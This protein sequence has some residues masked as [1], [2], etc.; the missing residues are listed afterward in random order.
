MRWTTFHEHG[1]GPDGSIYTFLPG[2]EF[3][4]LS[5]TDGS[6]INSAGVLQPIDTNL[7]PLTAVDA[8][9][10]V[11]V[12]NG[13][14]SNPV[15]NGRVWAFSPDLQTLL[16]TLVLNRQNIGGP[17]LAADGT[18]IVADLRGVFAYRE[19]LSPTPTPTATPTA[20]ATASSTATP[21]PTPT[22]T[23]R[24]SPSPRV[25]PTPAPRP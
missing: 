10:R 7:T 11:Y 12:S 2:N 8:D 23:P 24:A 21:T 18:L 13:W 15:T 25:R 1:I 19:V 5:S 16:F 3:V 20:T 17:S 4:R 22:S 6:V 9:G 14:A